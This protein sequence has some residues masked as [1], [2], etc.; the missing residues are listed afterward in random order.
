MS[1]YEPSP[2]E[3]NPYIRRTKKNIINSFYLT[4][5]GKKASVSTLWFLMEN[6]KLVCPNV[7]FYSSFRHRQTGYLAWRGEGQSVYTGWQFQGGPIDEYQAKSILAGWLK[8]V[9]K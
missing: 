6:I 4:A 2:H 5:A 9:P 8:E 1:Q 3:D 7:Y